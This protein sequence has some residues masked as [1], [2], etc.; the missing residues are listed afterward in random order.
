MKKASH[1]TLRGSSFM[2]FLTKFIE[3]ES[4]MVGASGFPGRRGQWGVKC[5]TV[6]KVSSGEDEEVLQMDGS[7]GYT[8]LYL[9]LQSYI[10]KMV[11]LLQ[12]FYHHKNHF[13]TITPKID[14]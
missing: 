1:E 3:T 6:Y 11:N 8:T 13:I 2:R 12:M 4:R 5:L 9:M 14:R 7:D 10:L